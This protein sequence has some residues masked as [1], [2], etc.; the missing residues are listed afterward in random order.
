MRNLAGVFIV[1]VL[2]GCGSSPMTNF[3]T[4]RVVPGQGASQASLL[5]PVQLAVVRIPP[6]LD[7]RQMVRMTGENSV[8]IK[9]AERWSGPLDEMIRNVLSQDLAARLAKGSVILP[10]APAPPETRMLVVTIVHFSPDATGH[11][12][13]NGSWSL[14][15]AGSN[16]PAL[17]RDFQIDG[18]SAANAEETAAAMSHA[19]GQLSDAMASILSRSKIAGSMGVRERRTGFSNLSLQQVGAVS[20]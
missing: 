14:L 9:D 17:Q 11:V 5:F 8:E 10:E 2:V 12:K 15:A 13:L 6:L 3:F 4:L 1:L 18:G 19:L 7:R 16:S 20:F